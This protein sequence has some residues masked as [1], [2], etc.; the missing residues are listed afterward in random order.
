MN[1]IK[2]LTTMAVL[3]DLTLSKWEGTKVDKET[4][5]EIMKTKDADES[6]GRFSKKLMTEVAPLAYIQRAMYSEY[7][8]LT[9]VWE[10][11]KKILPVINIDKLEKIEREYVQKLEDAL[12]AFRPH[13]DEYVNVNAKREL[14]KLWNKDDYL[15]FEEFKSKWRIRL[16]FFPIPESGH[17]VI[18]ANKRLMNEVKGRLDEAIKERYEGIVSDLWNKLYKTTKKL[19]ERLETDTIRFRED[20][21]VMESLREMIDILPTL[22]MTNDKE[23]TD[24][25]DVLKKKIAP[26]KDTDLR[27]DPVKTKTAKEVKKLLDKMAD[28]VA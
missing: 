18:D 1:E 19:V 11:G 7:E 14:G 27:K 16:E 9:A 12:E 22:N 17:F 24:M 5:R 2:G 10:K 13:Y 25:I 23:L 21:E 15:S 6:R 8:K 3:A 26:I 28:Y 4:N 20:R